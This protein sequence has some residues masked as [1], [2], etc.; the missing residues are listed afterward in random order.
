MT[1][2]AYYNEFDPFAAAWL[3]ELIK[4]GA[5]TDGD[6]DE[7][8]I[9]DV[10]PDDLRGY[11]RWH[12]FAGLGAWDYALN[13]A[14]WGDRKVLTCSAPCQPFSSAG[15]GE[16]TSDERHLWPT[17]FHI[18]SQ[19]KAPII[20]GEQVSSAINHGWWD[21]VE[22][23]LAGIG[24]E[25]GQKDF[26]ACSVGA[27]HKRQ[28]LYFV[29]ERKD[30][31]ADPEHT[32]WRPESE[33][34]FNSYRRDGFRRSGDPRDMVKPSGERCR[35]TQDSG[36]RSE[37]RIGDSGE[38][39]SLEHSPS[40]GWESWG[41]ESGGRGVVCG[42]ESSFPAHEGFVGH[43]D[44]TGPQGLV[45]GRNGAG[46]RIVGAPGVVD[47]SPLD[48]SQSAR[49]GI[50]YPKNIGSSDAQVN[51]SSDA[52]N[53]GI[54][55]SGF[56]VD[57]NSPIWLWCRDGKY[58]AVERATERELESLAP[59]FAADM[60]FMCDESGN[61]FISPL[62]EK[63]K[64]RVGRLRGYGNA[65]CAKAAQVFIESYLETQNNS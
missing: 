4:A 52:S 62:I 45:L 14:K 18:I 27:F 31:L 42:C 17:A 49:R 5:I 16:G 21:L 39:G 56:F 2:F 57:W 10:C 34:N 37:E 7:R 40:D 50:Q 28:R 9:E 35:E 44:D 38:S 47:A 46:E 22:D 43:A 41:T 54:D 11:T 53:S 20:F 59:G 63:G 64:N 58:R 12:L 32:I 55:G 24:Y 1:K 36:G 15:K 13:Q 30:E 23:D 19:L 65:L 51:T 48:D 29:G 33:T 6:V 25:V 3:R 26:P 60:G 8:N 61:G